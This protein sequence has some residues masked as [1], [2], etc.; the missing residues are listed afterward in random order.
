VSTLPQSTQ[1]VTSARHVRRHGR[2]RP[3]ALR[4]RPALLYSSLTLTYQRIGDAT[5]VTATSAL[6]GTVYFLWYVDGAYVATTKTGVR[7][8]TLAAG[9]QARVEVLATTDPAFDPIANAPTEWSARRS[10]WWC[11]SLATNVD[12]YTVEQAI[13]SGPFAVAAVV[14]QTPEA[15]ALGWLSARLADLTTYT[16]K[17]TPYDRAGNRGASRLFGPELVVRRPDGPRFTASVAAAHVTF[18]SA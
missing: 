2:Q 4:S 8:F 16:W 9:D 12:H 11:R 10:L 14:T 18:V 1:V 15:W 13:G 3:A 7:D 5:R 17:V 6:T